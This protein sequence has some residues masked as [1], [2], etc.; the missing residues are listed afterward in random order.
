MASLLPWTIAIPLI[1]AFL[2]VLTGRRPNLRETV[3]MLTAAALFLSV[4][5]L[6]PAVLGGER[7][8]LL[9]W[10]ILP[11]PDLMLRVEPLDDSLESIFSYIVER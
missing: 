9:I 1:G 6:T 3:T 5:S 7:P 11:G 2:I 10:N 4:V 8:S